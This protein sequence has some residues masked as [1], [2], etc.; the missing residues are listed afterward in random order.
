MVPTESG[1]HKLGRPVR[2]GECDLAGFERS[3][4]DTQDRCC[5]PRVLNSLLPGFTQ[6]IVNPD[7]SRPITYSGT[8][9][10]VRVLQIF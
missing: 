1:R 9:T 6:T 3:G 8:C 10:H 4:P 2:N 5:R 7:A